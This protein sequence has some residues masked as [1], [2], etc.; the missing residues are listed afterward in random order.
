MELDMGTDWRLL[1]IARNMIKAT[2]ILVIQ[3]NIIT[4]S[5]YRKDGH[6]AVYTIWLGR[7][8]ILHFCWLSVCVLPEVPDT[9]R[10]SLYARIIPDPDKY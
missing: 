9:W 3:L 8:L 7:N 4:L 1:D 2:K 5:E 10:E 6:T